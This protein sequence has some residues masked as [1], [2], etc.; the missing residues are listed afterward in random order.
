MPELS[1]FGDVEEVDNRY[2]DKCIVYVEGKDDQNV[3]ERIVGSELSDRLEFK[4]PLADGSGSET[5]LNRVKTERPRNAKIFGLVDGEVAARFGEVAQLI[6][7]SDV[8]FVLRMPVCDGIVFLSTH[9]LENVLVGH[10]C[11]AEFVESN[12]QL[13]EIGSRKKKEVEEHISRQARRFYAAALIKYAWAHMYFRGLASGIGNVDHFR[14]DH[15]L[16]EEVRNA[17]QKVVGEFA[18]KGLEF[19]RQLVK[20]G[21]KAR[22]RMDVVKSAGGNPEAEILRLAD[23]KG[24]LIKLRNHWK[25]TT[26]NEGLLVERVRLSDFAERFRAELVAVTGA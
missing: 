11:L 18:D 24:L 9:E 25:F 6:D 5:V 1:K 13:K 26:A 4:V 22:T 3:W 12:V 14:S 19:R 21:G 2:I 23:G 20:I 7:C 17:R 16:L 10:S 15:R 8:L